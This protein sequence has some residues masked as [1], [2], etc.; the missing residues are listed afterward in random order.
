[1]KV[2]GPA[3]APQE[4]DAMRIYIELL[5][6]REAVYCLLSEDGWR[7]DEANSGFTANHPAVRDEPAARNRLSALGLLTSPS[8]RIEF[9]PVAHRSRSRQPL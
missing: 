3:A 2:A 4:Q 8:V 7:L 9:G 1:M 6:H 5:R